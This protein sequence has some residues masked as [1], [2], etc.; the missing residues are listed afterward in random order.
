MND[1]TQSHGSPSS[2]PLSASAMA[3]ST[4]ADPSL[5]VPNPHVRQELGLR[6]PLAVARSQ[7]NY[8]VSSLFDELGLG[9]GGLGVHCLDSCLSEEEEEEEIGIALDS[10]VLFSELAIV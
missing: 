7:I 1:S 6:R 9:S 2:S 3:A 5:I 10:H 4:L 8:W